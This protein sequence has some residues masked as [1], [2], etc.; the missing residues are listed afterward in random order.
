MT[1]P[2]N[3]IQG[4]KEGFLRIRPNIFLVSSLLL[5]PAFLWLLPSTI[6]LTRYTGTETMIRTAGLA[7]LTVIIVALIVIW[8]WLAAGNRVAWIVIAVIVWVWAFFTMMEPL[9][10][11]GL[12]RSFSSSE[13]SDW[14]ALAWRGE[15]LA[16]IYLINTLMFLLMLVGLFLPVR[17]LF[18]I[19]KPESA[20]TSARGAFR[21]TEIILVSVGIL[22][23]VLTVVFLFRIWSKPPHVG[24]G[25]EWGEMG[26]RDGDREMERDGDRRGVF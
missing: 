12:L 6:Q 26:T 21:A 5:T 8:T 7:S 17:A 14:V 23:G 22:V 2:D 13:L 9:L 11:H 4:K 16:W 25:G 15:H 19:E 10:R 24:Y 20:I 3:S 18:R 1:N